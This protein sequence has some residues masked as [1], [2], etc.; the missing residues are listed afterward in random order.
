MYSVDIDSLVIYTSIKSNSMTEVKQISGE[1][2]SQWIKLNTDIIEFHKINN[3][4]EL[5]L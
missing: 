3:G 2:S 5:L 1:Q 4:Y